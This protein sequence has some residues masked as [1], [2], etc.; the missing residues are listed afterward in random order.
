ML[1]SHKNGRGKEGFPTRVQRERVL[2]GTLILLQR[3]YTGRV[4]IHGFPGLRAN[5]RNKYG[6]KQNQVSKLENNILISDGKR[7]KTEKSILA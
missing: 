2:D 6:D 5:G 4:S 7:W 3:K 1:C